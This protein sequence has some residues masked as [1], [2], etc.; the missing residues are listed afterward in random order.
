[1][2]GETDVSYSLSALVTEVE[3]VA[4]ATA[5][6]QEVSDNELSEVLSF[7]VKVSHVVEQA[8]R[9][10]LL[11]LIEIKFLRPNDLQ[12]DRMQRLRHKTE[13]VLARS[14]FRG[15]EGI[16]SRLRTLTE[17]YQTDLA[18]HVGPLSDAYRWEGLFGLIQHREGRIIV[19]IE[20]VMSSI[21][22]RL[23]SVNEA[24]LS[25]LTDYADRQAQVLKVELGTLS[26]F[27][28][29]ILGLS[30]RPGMLELLL[31]QGGRRTVVR[32]MSVLVNQGQIDMRKT[33]GG[34]HGV[35]LA[36]NATAQDIGLHQEWHAQTSDLSVLAGEL[37][38][39]RA[40]GKQLASTADH[41]I[42]VGQAA[43]AE[44]AARE[45][46]HGKVLAA[47]KGAG[48]WVLDLATSLGKDVAAEAIKRS[49]G[50]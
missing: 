32:E 4:L 38:E 29:R 11:I 5:Q 19:L 24:N 27:T 26:G 12:P 43:I 21:K 34:G 2:Q 17:T 49:L 6:S 33:Y 9:G 40:K 18:I 45:G 44:K 7:L 10:V 48:S 8:F 3:G 30:G 22:D 20:E 37:S 23:R 16:C 14:H 41:D 31:G 35:L 46:D 28:N 13:L 25:A 1:M 42:A 15:A 47:L 39:I 50:M 36:E